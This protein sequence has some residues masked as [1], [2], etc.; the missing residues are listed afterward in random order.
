M[1]YHVLAYYLLVA[2]LVFASSFTAFHSSEH[3]NSGSSTPNSH[4]ALNGINAKANKTRSHINFADHHT[5]FRSEHNHHA[6]HVDQ[7]QNPN[8]T[9][10]NQHEGIEQLCIT[11]LVLSNLTVAIHSLIFDIE[12]NKAQSG[13]L[14][15]ALI[16]QQNTLRSYQSRAPPPEA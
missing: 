13:S 9:H 16:T 14:H 2:S 15:Y 12:N 8:R 3:V 11:C 5:K 10:D 6:S 1:T 7:A 4:S